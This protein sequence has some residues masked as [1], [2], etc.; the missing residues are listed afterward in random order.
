MSK[1]HL[2]L[3]SDATGDTVHSVA[4]ACLVQFEDVEPVEH[5]WT[6]IRTKHQIERVIAGIR[7]NSGLVLYTLVNEALRGHLVE[8]CRRLQVPAIPVLEPVIGALAVFLGRQSRGLP[9]Q[10]HLLDSE[11]FHRIDAMTFALNHDD[12]QSASGLNDADVIL[13]G[14]SRTSKTPTCIYL[15]NR[16][17]KAANVPLVPGMAP[18]PE[19]LAASRP[20]IVGLTND[21]ERLIQVRR[22]RLS[23]L[24]HHEGTDYTDSEAVRAEV[25][26]A[27]R[28][29]TER[30][31]PV[32]DVTRR[33]IEE[34][35]AAILKLLARRQ[36]QEE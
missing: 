14:V 4:R 8:A 32:I 3:V 27:R 12:G 6:M 24:H 30:H 31:W 21:P 11:Y 36:G 34:T 5:I 2:H 10:Q 15:A 23:M 17:I 33:S 7:T 22:N 35:A 18:P 26:A 25:T 13:V 9:G 19:L 28:L 20:L 1:F 29:F 16:G